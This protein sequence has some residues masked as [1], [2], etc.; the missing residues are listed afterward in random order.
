MLYT[1]VMT[2]NYMQL[3]FKN[4]KCSLI[5]TSES[6]L[7]IRANTHKPTD[8]SEPLRIQYTLYVTS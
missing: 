7:S 8:I 6:D 3:T 4:M 1:S 2:H 5:C